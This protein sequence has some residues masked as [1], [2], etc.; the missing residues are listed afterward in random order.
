MPVGHDGMRAFHWVAALTIAADTAFL[1]LVFA[2][3]LRSDDSRLVLL[4]GVIAAVLGAHLVAVAVARR[5]GRP[6]RGTWALAAVQLVGALCATLL[7][8]DMWV[9]DLFLLGII[10]LQVAVADGVVRTH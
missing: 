1:G 4:A 8:S 10:P 9:L 2:A 6:D 3:I 7:V 5:Q